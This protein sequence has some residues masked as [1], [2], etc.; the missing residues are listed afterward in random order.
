MIRNLNEYGNFIASATYRPY[1]IRKECEKL[2]FIVEVHR[3]QCKS[4]A[5]CTKRVVR[6]YLLVQSIKKT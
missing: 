3:R 2:G 6:K 5:M 1:E 4:E